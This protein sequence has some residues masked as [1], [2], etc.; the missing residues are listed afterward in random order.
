MDMPKPNLSL[1]PE[2]P[3]PYPSLDPSA[4]TLVR[5]VQE[6]SLAHSLDDITQIVRRAARELAHADGATFVLRDDDRCYYVDEDAV[7]PLWKGMKFPMSAC[8]SGWCMLH[9]EQVT[10][11]DIYADDRIPHDAYRPTFVKSLAMTPIRKRDPIGAIGSY[12]ADHYTPTP[13][14]L[15][16]LS[17]L[18]DAA[19]IAVANVSTLT[20]LEHRIGALE[21]A[22]HQLNRLT[23]MAS[24]DLK[25]PLRNATLNASLLKAQ[26]LDLD[27][28]GEAVHRA[29]SQESR[30]LKQLDLIT[31]SCG[32]ANE[33]IKEL[34]E[35]ARV[36]N[37]EQSLRTVDLNEAVANVLPLL[38]TNIDETGADI[39]YGDLPEVY[40]DP[41]LLARV[42]QNLL[43]N[44]IKFHRQGEQPVIGIEAE[45]SG[46]H[47]RIAVR[48]NGIGI[49]KDFQERIFDYF[50]RLH[51]KQEY[52]GSGVGLA[53]CKS[54]IEGLGGEISVESEPD[55]GSCF[56]F[57]LPRSVT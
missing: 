4:A 27:H 12:W 21:K 52:A 47:W 19:S 44:A 46:S 30:I 29:G 22:N 15:D 8:I 55:K 14:E 11:E 39:R 18:A 35:I 34:L 6:L 48:D 31:A 54:I 2:S 20:E 36:E 42:L 3:K 16:L 7:G 43:S 56:Y 32:Q 23:W 53:L 41:V 13:K 40:A 50:T 5:V 28:F 57:T 1:V 10:I 38:E 17:A 26:I 24:H 49:E 45:P 33:L 51:G 25:E 9:K 37:Q